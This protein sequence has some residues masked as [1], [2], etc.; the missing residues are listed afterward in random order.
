MEEW[1]AIERAWEPSLMWRIKKAWQVL[2]TGKYQ[3]SMQYKISQD[4]ENLAAYI[5]DAR[6]IATDD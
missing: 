5:D 3:I 6:V 4:G 2:V 1:T